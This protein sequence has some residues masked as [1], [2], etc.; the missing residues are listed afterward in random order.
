MRRG[1]ALL[2]SRARRGHAYPKRASP[3]LPPLRL[4]T[5]RERT[6][7]G[8]SSSAASSRSQQAASSLSTSPARRRA[9]RCQMPSAA[10]ARAPSVVRQQ[11]WMQQ[12]P[13]VACEVRRRR[14]CEPWWHRRCRSGP[15]AAAGC[16]ARGFRESELYFLCLLIRSLLCSRGP[17]AP[18]TVQQCRLYQKSLSLGPYSSGVSHTLGRVRGRLTRRPGA[19]HR[20]PAKTPE[21]KRREHTLAQGTHM[22]Y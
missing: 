6:D 4:R 20:V 9:R 3:S 14:R 8:T 16:R 13:L 21:E 2:D 15:A 10:S 1:C 12:R 7:T 19:V 5:K 11:W 18:R 17:R 22:A